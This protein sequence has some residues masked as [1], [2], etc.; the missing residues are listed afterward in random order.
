MGTSIVMEEHYTG[1]QHSIPFVWM[2]LC[3][4][5]VFRNTLLT[6]LWFFAAWPLPASTSTSSSS[7]S[8]FSC[9]RNSSHYLSG[10]RLFKLSRLAGE[11]VFIHCFDCSLV[12]I[13]SPAHLWTFYIIVL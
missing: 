11:C 8:V 1:C 5:L 6:L 7:S 2:A 13:F 3:S 10:W 4:F 12:N 9:P